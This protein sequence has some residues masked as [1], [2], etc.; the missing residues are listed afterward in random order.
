M[1]FKKS[2]ISAGV[3]LAMAAGLSPYA[4][5]QQQLEKVQVTGSSIKRIVDTDTALPISVISADELR[6]TGINT[7]EGALAKIAASQSTQGSSQT[8]GS[9][10]GGVAYA[11]L[12]GLGANKTLVLLNGR[13][14]ASFAFSSAGVDL[15]SIPFAALDRV[16]VLRDGASAIY[17][18]DAIGGVINFITKKDYRGGDVAFSYAKPQDEGGVKRGLTLSGGFGDLE[19]QGFNLWASVDRQ[20][21]ERIRAIW[22]DFGATGLIPERGVLKTSGTT[23]PANL[24]QGEIA[25]NPTAA[26]G[27][28][29]PFSVRLTPTATTCRFDY[30]A[31]IDIVPDTR[32]TTGLIKGTAKVGDHYISLEHIASKNEN[33][34]RVAP[35]PVTGV[36]VPTTSPYYPS[37]FPGLDLT[38]P[39][40]VGWR[41]T[42]AG[43]RTNKSI[44]DAQRTALTTDGSIGNWDYRA[45]LLHATSKGKQTIVDGYVNKSLIAKGLADG[46]LNPFGDADAAALALIDAAKIRDTY[47]RA[48]G[49]TTSFDFNAST[50]LGKLPGGQLGLSVGAEYRKESYRNDSVDDIVNNVPSLGASAYHVGG[51]RN[52]SALS[53]EFLVPIVKELELTVAGRI[54]KYSD[55]GSTYNPKI[56]LRFTPIKSLNIRTSFNTGFRAPSLDEVFGPQAIT[57][58]QDPYD[59]PLLCPNGKVANGGLATRDCGQQGQLLTGGNLNLKPE[60]S[61][62][63]SLGVAFEPVKDL[64]AS[65]DYWNIRI[66]D[67]ISAVAEQALF[68]DPAK[69]A[70]RYFRCKDLPAATQALADRCQGE[71]AGSNALAYVK[72]LNDNLG[73]VKTDG[74]DLALGYGF[75]SALGQFQLGLESTY[76]RSYEYQR[77]KGDPYVQNAGRYVD[78]T[79]VLRWKHALS[80]SWKH[81]DIG[82]NVGVRY[83]SGYV[84]QNAVAAQYFNHVKAYTLTDASVTY[85]GIKFLKLTLGVNNL[86]DAKPPFSNQGTTF[87]Q[88]YDPRLTDPYGRTWTLRAAAKF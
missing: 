16:E 12:R 24:S 58:T 74:F 52:V 7:A 6:S 64:T 20:D 9:G 68:A 81:G 36:S 32:L 62:T 41:M 84:D 82:A 42:P 66:T 49:K 2:H 37:T 38:K 83:N 40:T 59:D 47:S 21:N 29:P 10:T 17:G 14:V 31:F 4:M 71:W 67:S 18:T 28:K 88:G 75:K 33:T 76:V 35:D 13:R 46:K 25:G 8:I 78:S 61:K 11:N 50:L 70:N 1:K 87:Q 15:N 73:G 53:T 5:A 63:F 23:F 69:Y 72:A 39:V 51:K 79:P 77:D 27:C 22:R 86:F 60:K 80:S 44:V 48:T 3:M 57:Y 54:D 43:A 56:A 55:F 26:A 19:S 85:S 34:A 45:G 30:T 65:V